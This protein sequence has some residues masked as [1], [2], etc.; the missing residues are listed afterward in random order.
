[1][2]CKYA[3]SVEIIEVFSL[4]IIVNHTVVFQWEI[5]CLLS[6]ISLRLIFIYCASSIA[7][8]LNSLHHFWNQLIEFIIQYANFE[9]CN[10]IPL[11]FVVKA[12]A[13]PNYYIRLVWERNSEDNVF[14]VFF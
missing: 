13:P 1:M 6:V 11:N 5:S 2:I 4:V 12:L 10:F 3:I 14:A 8:F 7:S 9:I